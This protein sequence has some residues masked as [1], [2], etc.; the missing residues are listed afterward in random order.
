VAIYDAGV[1]HA[2]IS[3]K[4]LPLPGRLLSVR[5][6]PNDDLLILNVICPVCGRSVVAFA[7]RFRATLAY[8]LRIE[9]IRYAHHTH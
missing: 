2:S 8:Y 9:E 6:G 3:S 1:S 7:T 4:A 5:G